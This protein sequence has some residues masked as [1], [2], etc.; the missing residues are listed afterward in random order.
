MKKFI[1]GCSITALS[2]IVVGIVVL[3]MITIVRGP[4]FM[5]DFIYDFANGENSYWYELINR[6]ASYDTYEGLDIEDASM[7][8]GEY[9]THKGSAS[10]QFDSENVTGLELE[11][12]GCAFYLAPSN[13]N[14]FYVEGE[15]AGTIQAYQENGVIYVKST[16][17]NKYWEQN[18]YSE[19]LL[20]VPNGFQFDTVNI[21]VGAG[22]ADI[23]SISAANVTF[24]VGAGSIDVYDVTTDQLTAR[25]GAGQIDMQNAKCKNAD[26][27]AEAGYICLDGA[28]QGNLKADSSVGNIELSLEGAVEDY[29][30]EIQTSVGI[31]SVDSMSLS[32][33]DKTRSISHGSDKTIDLKSS[34][35]SIDV[36]FY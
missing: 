29:N 22:T 36:S 2:M 17:T 20:Y 31:I 13:D 24:K 32:G 23:E 10:F 18:G 11:L 6:S 35:G 26:L 19:L 25:A 5:N 28:V 16:T 30:Y 15:N 14:K 7:Y 33:M 3:A 21:E 12:G 34:A 8:N 1:K 27:I 9:A 4:R